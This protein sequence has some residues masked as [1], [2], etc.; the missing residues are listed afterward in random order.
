MIT[1]VPHIKNFTDEQAPGLKKFVICIHGFG[2]GK[3]SSK[4]ARLMKELAGNGIG[5]VA[6]DLPAHGENK[7]EFT[8]DNCVRDIQEIEGH[9]RKFNKPIGF[10]G[11][12][13]GAYTTMARLIG[14]QGSYDRVILLAPVIDAYPRYLKREGE[15]Y[16]KILISPDFVKSCKNYDVFA[17]ADKLPKL[18]IIY[19]ELDTMVDNK[20]IFTLAEIADCN[21]Y[22]IKNA[23]HS[24][25]GPGELD[26]IIDIAL[27]VFCD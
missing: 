12:S 6:I 14:N 10:Y 26:Q 13:F 24:F 22:Q 21:L 3:H 15:T 8:I 1:N 17:N 18:D 23:D 7:N 25:D 11:S 9:L 4:I 5:A 2:T 16:A 19:A 20:E 27:K